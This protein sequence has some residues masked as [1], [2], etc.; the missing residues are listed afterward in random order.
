MKFSDLELADNWEAYQAWKGKR[1]VDSFGCLKGVEVPESLL[2]EDLA[3]EPYLLMLYRYIS[4]SGYNFV[5]QG[6]EQE[7]FDLM[8]K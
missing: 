7:I 5:G 1:L 4:K 6:D 3:N 2:D 8:G